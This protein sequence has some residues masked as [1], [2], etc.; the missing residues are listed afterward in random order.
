MEKR[1]PV[2]L[3]YHL[4][5]SCLPSGF[6]RGLFMPFG[7]R[8]CPTHQPTPTTHSSSSSLH[9]LFCLSLLPPHRLNSLVFVLPS[10]LFYPSPSTYNARQGFQTTCQSHN[11]MM[12]MM[13]KNAFFCRTKGTN[14]CWRLCCLTLS[15]TFVVSKTCSRNSF[16]S[17]SWP[18]TESAFPH[19]ESPRRYYCRLNPALRHYTF[20]R[21]PLINFLKQPWRKMQAYRSK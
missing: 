7:N 11:M 16:P 21:E 9:F 10:S 19:D 1:L 17:L 13:V 5:R 18:R 3:S 14:Q 12:M 6:S 20:F 15:R 8:F 4:L 2:C